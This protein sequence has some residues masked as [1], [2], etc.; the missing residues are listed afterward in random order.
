VALINESHQQLDQLRNDLTATLAQQGEQTHHRLQEV[1]TALTE[2]RQAVEQVPHLL[3]LQTEDQADTLR[4][5]QRE[6]E[7][8]LERHACDIEDALRGVRQEVAAERTGIM[9]ALESLKLAWQQRV[10]TLEQ[11]IATLRSQL[12]EEVQA[13]E[14]LAQRVATSAGSRTTQQRRKPQA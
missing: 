5:R 7:A 9:Q 11:Q 13:R 10:E 12:H 1:E 3:S 4:A 14:K 6:I 8:L 2:Q